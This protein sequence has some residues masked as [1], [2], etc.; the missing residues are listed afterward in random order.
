MGKTVYIVRFCDR[1]EENDLAVF[2]SKQAAVEYLK[3]EYKGVDFF[4]EDTTPLKL[5]WYDNEQTF[6]DDADDACFVT[7]AYNVIE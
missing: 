4:D 7:S 5:D 6:F 1:K 3:A 2:A